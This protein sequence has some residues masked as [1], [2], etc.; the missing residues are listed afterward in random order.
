M[1]TIN[2]WDYV[3]IVSDKKLKGSGLTRGMTLLVAG[4]QLVPAS[5]KD[6]HLYRLILKTMVVDGLTVLTPK[7]DNSNAI[8]LVDPRSVDKIVGE[9][10]ATLKT[11]L[12]MQ[13][14]GSA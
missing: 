9:E 14:S 7:E 2:T 1:S 10:E 11:A 4:T 8:Y 3:R 13:M 6:P 12:E 5:K